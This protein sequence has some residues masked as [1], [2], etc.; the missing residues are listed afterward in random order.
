MQFFTKTNWVSSNKEKTKKYKLKEKHLSERMST[1][2]VQDL[3]PKAFAILLA[4]FIMGKDNSQNIKCY[5]PGKIPEFEEYSTDSCY[6]R[7]VFSPNPM[8][9][10]DFSENN[11]IYMKHY[12][13][14]IT[15]FTVC[16]LFFVVIT[17]I[18]NR[19]LPDIKELVSSVHSVYILL[20]EKEEVSNLNELRKKARNIQLMAFESFGRTTN[21][22]F[23]YTVSKLV[24]SVICLVMISLFFD[25]KDLSQGG[26]SGALQIFKAKYSPE[27]YCVYKVMD[28]VAPNNKFRTPNLYLL[29]CSLPS[30]IVGYY[31]ALFAV[32]FL[33]GTFFLNIADAILVW[34]MVNPDD[35]T[36]IFFYMRPK[37]KE[38]IR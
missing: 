12:S 10:T 37:H 38:I 11:R 27:G 9:K 22:Q 21:F 23:R 20:T 36:S 8:N 31:L 30:N 15:I 34:I 33:L 13:V 6:F 18:E 19:L 4:L 26:M 1:I 7:D 3:G 5:M 28:Q 17:E 25:T 2:L 16:Q 14:L 32:V 24:T 35:A 29:Q